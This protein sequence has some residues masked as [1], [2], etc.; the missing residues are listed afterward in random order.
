MPEDIKSKIVATIQFRTAGVLTALSQNISLLGICAVFILICIPYLDLVP[1]FDAAKYWD[2]IIDGVNSDFQ[3]Q[4]FVSAGH[5]PGF[6]ML[7]G[8]TQLITPGQILLANLLCVSLGVC[9]IFAFYGLLLRIF[10]GTQYRTEIAGVTALYALLPAFVANS[11]FTNLDFGVLVFWVPCL[12]FLLAERFLLC[13]LCASMMIL[14]KENSIVLYVAAVSLYLLLNIT[15]IPDLSLHNKLRRLWQRRV[16][17]LPLLVTIGAAYYLYYLGDSPQR[18]YLKHYR[19]AYYRPE[20]YGEVFLHFN[21]FWGNVGVFCADI[22]VL[23]F[24][25]LM[26]AIIL[27]LICKRAGQWVFALQPQQQ[28]GVSRSSIVLCSVLLIITTYWIT[29]SIVWNNV[30]YVLPAF[31]LL[32]IIFYF[33]LTSLCRNSYLRKVVLVFIGALFLISNYRTIDPVSK[34]L[35]GTVPFGTHE[36]LA[37]QD[38]GTDQT[39]PRDAL[40]Y[41]LESFNIH[42]LLNQAFVALKVQP[43]TR[44]IGGYNF[45]QSYIHRDSYQRVHRDDANSFGIRIRHSSRD[46]TSLSPQL[47]HFY[48][49]GFP[50]TQIPMQ[51]RWIIQRNWKF[52]QGFTFEHNG[53]HLIVHK[54]VRLSDRERALAA[55]QP[56]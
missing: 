25:W 39:M 28:P 3:P 8:L 10:H 32:I 38:F 11:L 17:G 56:R 22:F 46:L 52:D 13:S 19:D 47:S 4:A 15:R 43:S 44:I 21:I 34:K 7:L 18:S 54:F 50:L 53:Y 42:Y 23:N 29:R 33:S 9:S 27:G 41:N 2:A 49:F 24:N 51:W 16:L 35:F 45:G 36:V 20:W 6:L 55:A 1:I 5:F 40:V 48:L 31:P 26:S 12:Y 14:C 37:M 30:R